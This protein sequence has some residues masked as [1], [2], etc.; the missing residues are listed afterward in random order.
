MCLFECLHLA[1]ISFRLFKRLGCC[2]F[3]ICIFSSVHIYIYIYTHRIIEVPRAQTV[4]SRISISISLSFSP[5]CL[6]F[7]PDSLPFSL[8]LC[9]S[10]SRS[11]SLFLFLCSSFSSVFFFISAST[12]FHYLPLFLYLN[13]SLSH[14][15]S[16]SLSLSQNYY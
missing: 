1:S 16:L 9:S 8:S 5:G 7:Y 12:F 2:D 11:I 3:R 14:T 15:L 13:L 10:F 4:C 6:S